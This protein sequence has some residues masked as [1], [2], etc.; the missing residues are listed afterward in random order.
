ME[1]FDYYTEYKSLDE[2]KKV[3]SALARELAEN[4]PDT[5]NVEYLNVYQLPRTK[6]HSL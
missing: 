4:K 2:L 5:K 3:D 6:V 1:K